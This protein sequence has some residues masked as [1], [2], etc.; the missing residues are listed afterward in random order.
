MNMNNALGANLIK[1]FNRK[2][3]E[4][5]LDHPEPLISA[6]GY[7]I[8]LVT[9][10][11]TPNH[12]IVRCAVRMPFDEDEDLN[13]SA[14]NADG[15]N[16]S[17][18]CVFMGKNDVR[19]RVG[20][21][22]V[23]K[24]L[25]FS[26]F[27]PYPEQDLI[28]QVVNS[29][30]K[31]VIHEQLFLGS[32]IASLRSQQDDVLYKNASNDPYYKEW[33]NNNQRLSE[34]EL[35][36][37]REAKLN[38]EPKFSI[39]IPLYKTPLKF[40]NELAESIKNQSYEG[41]E[42]ILVNASPED[43][44]LEKAV[45]FVCKQDERIKSIELN[46][47]EGIT[48]NT[49]HGID[50]ATGDFVCFVDHDDVLEPNCLFEYAQCINEKPETD[51]LYCDEDQ[52]Y[53]DGNVG[54][55]FF[56]PDF[57]LHLLRS[58]N[59][60]CHMLCIRRSFLQKLDYKQSAFDGAQD[61]NLTLQ[62]VEKTSNICHIPKVLYHWRAHEGSVAGSTDSKPYAVKKV[63]EA[64]TAHLNRQNVD[65]V[66]AEDDKWPFS[67]RVD[68]AVPKDHPLVSIIIPTHDNVGILKRCVDSILKKTTY[69]NYEV[70]LVENNSKEQ[71]TFDYY[72]AI[73]DNKKVRVIVSNT[74]PNVAR[75]NNQGSAEARGEYLVLMNNDTEVITPNWLELMLGICSQ[76]E[77]GEV[78]CKLLFPDE[79]IQHAGVVIGN[80]PKSLFINLPNGETGYF[81]F[82]NTQRE[83][84]ALTS[85]CVMTKANL[86]DE[87]GG[88]DEELP[89][90]YND[91]DYSFKV[92][93]SGLLTIY[94]PYVE[95]YHYESASRG[96]DVNVNALSNH[97][98]ARG[99]MMKKWPEIYA[100]PDVYSSPHLRRD[101]GCFYYSL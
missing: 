40:F 67:T 48:L 66:V 55:V 13:V 91:I 58:V 41:W 95:L 72:K 27:V 33:F 93:Q 4:T 79:T 36:M 43:I 3:T 49:A 39:V 44:E 34:F 21:K 54:E 19:N 61:L 1:L 29:E 22:R 20:E 57:S 26:V 101:S 74:P 83:V 15:N 23:Y 42:L 65:A 37:Q 9:V 5:S 88:F 46:D 63:V 24:E 51:L 7:I 18:K 64:V 99:Y 96:T 8:S 6:P 73:E 28:F 52:L 71:E 11:S 76:P 87:L 100:T 14:K 90:D 25:V 70:V 94:T 80:E 17:L 56:K 86:Y 75:Y 69:D 35:Q 45:N 98:F 50:A 77:V 68:Y 82:P 92:R 81:A 97:I 30:D 62:A 38:F 59:Y 53:D 89:F 31:K 10:I 47:N 12:I 2:Q 60:V 85:A 16:F 32:H 78:G 84:G